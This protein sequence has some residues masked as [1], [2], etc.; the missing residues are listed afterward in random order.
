MIIGSLPV[1]LLVIMYFLESLKK[2]PENILS[3]DSDS[4]QL[5][6]FVFFS[7]FLVFSRLFAKLIFCTLP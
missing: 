1:W 7:F 6:F 3:K 4:S 5:A 2:K